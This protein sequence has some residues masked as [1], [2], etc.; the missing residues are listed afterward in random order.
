MTKE[1]ISLIFSYILKSAMNSLHTFVH[2]VSLNETHSFRNT[3][4]LNQHFGVFLNMFSVR[5]N[6]LT[7]NKTFF[8]Q[9]IYAKL[10]IVIPIPCLISRVIVLCNKHA[11]KFFSPRIIL[12]H[13][14]RSN[15]TKELPLEYLLRYER[16]PFG[17]FH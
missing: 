11:R 5:N 12:T 17:K 14:K 15:S 8:L 10:L 4:Q 9:N 7:N 2:I 1:K 13:L 3:S 6:S 16:I